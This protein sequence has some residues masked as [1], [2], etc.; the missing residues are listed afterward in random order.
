M[1]KFSKGQMTRLQGVSIEQFKH[2]AVQHLRQHHTDVC[3]RRDDAALLRHV[4][5]MLAF[6]RSVGVVQQ[7][8][9]LRMLDLQLQ[10]AWAPPLG[11]YLA[12]RL[13]QRGFDEGL[14][15]AHF[16]QA[17]DMPRHPEVI[18]LDT[19]LDLPGLCNA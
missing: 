18:S 14:R 10:H 16:A 19:P 11:S 5:A 9:V 13:T 1:L 2:R 4:D 15:V 7:P 6:C 17:L 12:W 3:E 8:N